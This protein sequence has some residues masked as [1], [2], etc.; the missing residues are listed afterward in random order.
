VA[1]PTVNSFRGKTS[2][3]P[4]KAKIVLM[5]MTIINRYHKPILQKIVVFYWYTLDPEVDKMQPCSFRNPSLNLENFGK[6]HILS[7]SG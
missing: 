5:D 4:E 2:D 6:S 1:S 3:T 7:T